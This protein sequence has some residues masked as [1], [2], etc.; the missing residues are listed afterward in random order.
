[1]EY[2]KRHHAYRPTIGG[3]SVPASKMINDLE[4]DAIYYI[5]TFSEYNPIGINNGMLVTVRKKTDSIYPKRDFKLKGFNLSGGLNTCGGNI[6]CNQS[7]GFT[8]TQLL[9]IC[10]AMDEDDSLLISEVSNYPRGNV[11]DMVALSKDIETVVGEI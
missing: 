1:M 10:A 9:Q 3:R 8:K 11:R 6:T 2:D 5:G 4:K 7:I